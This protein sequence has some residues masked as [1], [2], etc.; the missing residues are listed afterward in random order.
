MTDR[1]SLQGGTLY[2]DRLKAENERMRNGILNWLR[3]VDK[4]RDVNAHWAD[5]EYFSSLLGGKS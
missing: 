2:V 5:Y 1:N 3:M 4:T